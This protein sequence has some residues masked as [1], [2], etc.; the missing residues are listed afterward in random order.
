MSLRARP[1]RQGSRRSIPGASPGAWMALAGTAATGPAGAQ[2]AYVLRRSPGQMARPGGR[3][4]R[5]PGPSSRADAVG[6]DKQV[7]EAT[8]AVRV[9]ECLFDTGGDRGFR[10]QFPV[11]DS[12]GGKVDNV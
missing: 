11:R 4:G 1:G 12:L 8:F 7:V 2:D 3:R 9:K 5:G 6:G 10:P